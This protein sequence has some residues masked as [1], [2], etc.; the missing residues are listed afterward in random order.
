MGNKPM[1]TMTGSNGSLLE[2]LRAHFTE[3]DKD[4]EPRNGPV[5]EIQHICQKAS[6]KLLFPQTTGNK[7]VEA[8]EARMND[9]IGKI[10]ARHDM[11]R[12]V[13]FEKMRVSQQRFVTKTQRTLQQVSSRSARVQKQMQR[14]EDDM[15]A[16]RNVYGGT[17]EALGALRQ[18]AVNETGAVEMEDCARP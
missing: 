9:C 3:R 14:L 18:C 6:E 12:D 17:T 4:E 5:S 7:L 11:E 13:A 16:R 2:D 1:G 8:Y 15:K 10:E